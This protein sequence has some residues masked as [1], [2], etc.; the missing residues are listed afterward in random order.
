MA[1][2]I[3]NEKRADIIKHMQAGES[4]ENI[5]KWLLVCV[6]TVTRVWNKFTVFGSYEPEPQGSGRKPLVSDKVMDQVVLKIKETPDITLLELIDEFSLPISE[7]ALCKR[8][9]KLG[10]SFKKRQLIR[11]SKTAP[12]SKKNAKSS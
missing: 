6:R 4:K 8:L 12:T 10:F 7:S 2:P 5:A 9:I 11:Q 1:K 3:S